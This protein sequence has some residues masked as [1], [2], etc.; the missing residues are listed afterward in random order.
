MA[1]EEVVMAKVKR[2]GPCPCGSGNKAKR[3]CYGIGEANGFH[4]LPSDLCE[5]LIDDLIGVPEL[6]LRALFD[7]LLYLPEMDVAL[8]VRLPGI[9]TPVI[10]RAINALRDD[11]DE[12]FDR[13]LEE[14]VADLDT[15]DRRLELAR[16]VI[17]LRDEG[18]LPPALVAAAV[19]E[20]DQPESIL[21]R[22]SV[23]ESIAVLAGDQR[24]P[25]GLLVA[26]R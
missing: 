20:L 18:C 11:E 6:E 13:V 2:N 26:T 21:F 7:Q 14:V 4:V 15:D 24:T 16:A 22:S 23:A 9:I 17:A 12:L 25:A 10:D 1:P 5:G 19:L 8:Q 3:C